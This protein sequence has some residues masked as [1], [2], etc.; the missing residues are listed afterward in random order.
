M[1]ELIDCWIFFTKDHCFVKFFLKKISKNLLNTKNIIF[2]V[3]FKKN[4]NINKKINIDSHMDYK[5]RRYTAN[6]HHYL[7]IAKIDGEHEHLA[8]PATY[9]LNVATDTSVQV[10]VSFFK[11]KQ[12][13]HQ[14]K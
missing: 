12:L 10:K 9:Y 7:V 4:N 5:A 8:G 1:F 11:K 3:F 14:L 2:D 6:A 13:K